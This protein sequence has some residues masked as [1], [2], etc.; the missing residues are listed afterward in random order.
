M[1]Q[2][3][4]L[5]AEVK[6][7]FAGVPALVTYAGL[8]PGYVGL[9]QFNIVVPSIAHSDTVPVALTLTGGTNSQS[10]AIAIANP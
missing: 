10:L 2:T 5:Q 8:A 6:I 4:A 7:T 3:N 9:Y 1:Q